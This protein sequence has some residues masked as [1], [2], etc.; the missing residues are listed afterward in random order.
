MTGSL[1]FEVGGANLT[2]HDGG[3]TCSATR[4]GKWHCRPFSVCYTRQE[5]LP[6]FDGHCELRHPRKDKLIAEPPVPD[7]A[8][9]AVLP[10]KPQGDGEIQFRAAAEFPGSLPGQSPG[11]VHDAGK[12]Y[13]SGGFHG[14]VLF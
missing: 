13:A 12:K 5:E 14:I 1:T 6:F 7:G 2:K 4:G 9:A 10:D 8:R 11:F 3:R